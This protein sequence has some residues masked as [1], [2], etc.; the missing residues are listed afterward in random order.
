M[1][2]LLIVRGAPGVGKS[3]VGKLLTIHYR[4]GLTIEIDEIRRMKNR[5]DWTCVEEHLNAIEATGSLINSYLEF[6]YKPIMVFDTLSMGTIQMITD[7]I[8][9]GR[10]YK[11]IS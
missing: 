11:I 10:S 3:S 5:V 7:K 9:S 6:N 2:D 1:T 8:P 4:N